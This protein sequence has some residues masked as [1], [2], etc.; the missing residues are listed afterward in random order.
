MAINMTRRSFLAG[1]TATAAVAGTAK[2]MMAPTVDD[3]LSVFL[4]DLH[5]RDPQC[6]QYRYFAAIVDE[7]LSLNPRPKHVVV[8]GDIAYTCGLK[9]EYETSRPL[10]QK[11]ID[12]GM[13]ITFGMG[14]HDRRSAFLSVWPEYRKRTLLP[15]KIVSLADLG[16]V[17]LLMLD[18]LQGTDDRADNDMGPVDGKLDKEQEDWLYEYLKGL[19]KP[20]LLASH[21]PLRDMRGT[22]K[23]AFAD[24]FRDYPLVAGYVYG[25]LHRWDPYW[26]KYG[27]GMSKLLRNVCLPSTGHWGDIGYVLFHAE[28]RKGTAK[29]VQKDFFFRA[30]TNEDGTRQP[31]WDDILA[32]RSRDLVCTFRW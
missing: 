17:D 11:L 20:T 13:D 19:K 7:I 14:N 31:E 15:G 9:P 21:Y 1:A 2:A 5:V 23:R 26:T 18:G 10:F 3:N 4:S 22:G 16:P 25:H 8:F 30:P 12:A 32:D 27:W 6:H 24:H 28:A 29:F